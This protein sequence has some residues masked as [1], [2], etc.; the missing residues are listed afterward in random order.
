MAERFYNSKLFAPLFYFLLNVI[1]FTPFFFGGK[2]PIDSNPLYRSYPWRAQ[3][4]AS[5]LRERFH[6]R[7]YHHVDQTLQLYPLRNEIRNQLHNGQAPLWTDLVFCGAPLLGNPVGTFSF[8]S[9]LQYILPQWI[10]YSL[11]I[12]LEFVLMGWFM[13]LFCSELKLGRLGALLAGTAFMWNGYFLRWFG[14]ISY[15]ETL[16]WM[17][18]LLYF[19]HRCLTRTDRWA[20]HG[21]VFAVFAQFLGE[22]SQNWLYN[23]SLLFLYSL[24]LLIRSKDQRLRFGIRILGACVLGTLLASPDLLS[25]YSAFQNSPRS[26]EAAP[27]YEGRNHVSPRK[28]ITIA[29]PDFYG[30]TELNVFSRLILKP[31][32]EG[33]GNIW[34]RLVLGELGSVYNRVWVYVGLIPFILALIALTDRRSR[35]WSILGVFPI[36]LLIA[37]NIDFIHRAAQSVVPG[38]D[39]LDQT[40]LLIFT[41]ISFCALSGYGFDRLL[42]DPVFCKRVAK[43]CIGFAALLAVTITALWLCT[44]VF[45]TQLVTAADSYF[46][47]QAHLDSTASFYTEGAEAIPQMFRQ[48]IPILIFPFLLLSAFAAFL[49][50]GNKTPAMI[51]LLTVLDLFYHGRTDPPVYFSNA[52]EMY[53]STASIDFLKKHQQDYRVLEIQNRRPFL[54]KPLNHYSQLGLYRRRGNRYFDFDAFNFVARP[55]SLIPYGIRSA[56]GYLSIYP[57]RFRELWKGRGN[58]TLQFAKSE[59]DIDRWKGGWIDMQ[60]IR[61]ILADPNAESSVFR[62]IYRDEGLTIFENT[63]ALP[64]L[65]F[66]DRLAVVPAALEKLRSPDFDPHKEAVVEE[67]VSFQPGSNVLQVS[68]SVVGQNPG[69]V[70][71]I[72]RTNKDAVLIFSENYFPGW[73]CNID[74]KSANIFRANY[75]FMG[76]VIPAGEHTVSFKFSPPEFTWGMRIFVIGLLSW[77]AIFF[78]TARSGTGVRKE[79]ME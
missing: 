46:S 35:F 52:S 47:A 28:L 25:F 2:I 15:V 42:S 71:V 36:L 5:V 51:L 49:F 8:P 64:R 69:M 12:V 40:R 27:L 6:A 78:F 79:I 3:A 33:Q 31:N 72:S 65:F 50:T 44:S 60:A 30:R 77:V 59:E 26:A 22:H 55:D 66:V 34:R 16:L 39:M 48:S 74:G 11:G 62:A 21:L 17:P 13:F 58:D 18:L 41:I 14:V 43:V 63:N 10:G 29:I 24:A 76:A 68:M 73:E 53:P 37:L 57:R 38:F 67:P 23:L 75:T 9:I 54:E 70:R 32:T 61:F 7:D 45:A 4:S 56:G 1:F 20:F 19:A